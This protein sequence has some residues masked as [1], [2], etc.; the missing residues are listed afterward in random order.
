[1]KL[2]QKTG[3]LRSDMDPV[4]FKSILDPVVLQSD[5]D[6]R[7]NYCKIRS[8][9]RKRIGKTGSSINPSWFNPAYLGYRDEVD[10]LLPGLV[11]LDFVDAVEYDS[12]A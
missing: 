10:L 4:L 6:P 11:Q 9:S 3:F 2:I 1:M 7:T 5:L 8:I 12:P